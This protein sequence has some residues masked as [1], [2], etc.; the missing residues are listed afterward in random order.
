MSN[1]PGDRRLP[2]YENNVFLIY[3]HA[4]NAGDWTTALHACVDMCIA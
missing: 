2:D 3:R 4:D 1:G